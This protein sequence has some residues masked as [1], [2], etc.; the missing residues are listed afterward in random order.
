[1][2]TYHSLRFLFLFEHEKITLKYSKYNEQIFIE[3]A[4]KQSV[5]NLFIKK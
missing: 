4:H 3:N 1:L 5:A 2:F